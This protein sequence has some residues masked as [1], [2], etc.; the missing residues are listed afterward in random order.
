MFIYLVFDKH[1]NVLVTPKRPI[2]IKACKF[3]KPTFFS[4]VLIHNS[5]EKQLTRHFFLFSHN[6][7]LVAIDTLL[8]SS[9]KKIHNWSFDHPPNS[10]SQTQIEYQKT[11]TD[12]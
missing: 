2:K 10:Y 7:S 5:E 1:I 8:I 4:S 11:Q 6:D 12:K 9:G 3:H